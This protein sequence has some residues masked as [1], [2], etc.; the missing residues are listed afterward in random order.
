MKEWKNEGIKIFWRK[1]TDF[2]SFREVVRKLP[3]AV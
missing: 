2:F 1:T 3:D